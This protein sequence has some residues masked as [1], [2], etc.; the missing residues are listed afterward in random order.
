[1][2]AA[3]GGVRAWALQRATSLVA[4]AV[5]LYFLLH[6]L[7]V[8]PA[9][10]AAWRDWVLS[11]PM[12]TALIVFFVA[13]ALHAWVGIRD[14]ILDYVKPLG[15]RLASLLML[16]LWLAVTCAWAAAILFP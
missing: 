11:A 6:L 7:V 8:P 1:M 15:W 10:H 4:L 13:T 12:R 14:V 2:K 16:A 9:S 3:L 5:L